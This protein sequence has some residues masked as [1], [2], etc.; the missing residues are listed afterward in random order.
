[1]NDYKEKI[2]GFLDKLSVS[3]IEFLYHFAT[4]LFGHAPD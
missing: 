1:M 3:Q 2:I 4:K